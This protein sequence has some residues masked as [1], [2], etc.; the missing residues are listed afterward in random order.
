MSERIEGILALPA[1]LAPG[2]LAYGERIEAIDA[3]PGATTEAAAQS[4]LDEVRRGAAPLILPG[5]IDG[6]VHGGGGGDTMDG[7]DGVRT[8]AAFH[9]RH[10]T[11]TLLPTTIT[12]PWPDVLRAL[13]GVHTVMDDPVAPYGG[14]L[15]SIRVRTS[16][17]PSSA[18]TGSARSRP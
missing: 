7:A 9:L 2:S 6:H 11:T 14:P 4:L 16:R 3:E 1:G 15:P 8:L 13:Q 18:P 5:F 10:G 12:N 17:G